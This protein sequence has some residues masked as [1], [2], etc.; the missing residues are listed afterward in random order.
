M[1][2]AYLYILLDQ[3]INVSGLEEEGQEGHNFR[4]LIVLFTMWRSTLSFS[5]KVV[6]FL[7]IPQYR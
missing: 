5:F 7:L 6:G 1:P 2:K 3:H 4:I